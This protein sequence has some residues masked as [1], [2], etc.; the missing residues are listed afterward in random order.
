MKLEARCLARTEM[1]Q[2]AGELA[3]WGFG[4]KVDGAQSFR[5]SLVENKTPPW[6]T[7]GLGISLQSQVGHLTSRS[8][9]TSSRSFWPCSRARSFGALVSLSPSKPFLW[10]LLQKPIS[11][12]KAQCCKVL[13]CF[14]RDLGIFVARIGISQMDWTC[15]YWTCCYWTLDRCLSCSAN[16]FITSL[17]L[18]LAIDDVRRICLSDYQWHLILLDK[19]RSYQRVYGWIWEKAFTDADN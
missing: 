2:Q 14:A 15:C 18:L 13:E 8:A 12:R 11:R 5:D 17:N 4:E 3:V 6:L 19:S 16:K 10:F 7:N 1:Y 9:L